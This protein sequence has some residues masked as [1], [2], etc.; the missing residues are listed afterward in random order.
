MTL[1]GR[2]TQEALVELAS[3]VLQDKTLSDVL[4]HVAAIAKRAIPG[5]DEVSMTLVR[6][7]RG[8]TAAYTGQL[9]LD[10]DEL[11][12]ARGFG[13]CLDAG[14]AGVMIHIVDMREE[15]RYPDYASHVLE[16]GVL[17]S[18]SLPLPVQDRSIGALN[19]YSRTERAFDEESIEV[20]TTIA[21]FVAVAVAN[22]R[23]YVEAAAYAAQ[24]RDAMVSRAAI[25]QA[26]GILMAQ[27]GC[28]AD[29]AFAIL[30]KT[31]QDTNR[32]LRDVAAALVET[33][34]RG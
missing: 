30:V 19:I 16:R 2:H 4:D 15:T 34:Q 23:E 14:R 21:G 6:D 12:Y 22:A 8:F 7:D 9:A 29:D 3:V 17:S 13:P 11:Q 1:R 24:M 20:G 28:T 25:E 27:R 18:L 32:K 10:A 5:A 33:T 31:S 26:K